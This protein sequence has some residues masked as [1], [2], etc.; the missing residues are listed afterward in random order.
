MPPSK[1][2]DSARH[3][4]HS[5]SAF[6]LGAIFRTMD[7]SLFSVAD[8]TPAGGDET[9]FQ[10]VHHEDKAIADAAKPSCGR[11]LSPRRASP[12][13]P[14]LRAE[15]SSLL[16]PT[17]FW[18]VF[19]VVRTRII[20]VYGR[21]HPQY[22]GKEHHYDCEEHG[23]QLTVRQHR[24]NPP[25]HGNRQTSLVGSPKAYDCAYF[26]HKDSSDRY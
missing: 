25:D 23:S 24:G 19:A 2:H 17:I 12:A 16:R 15:P 3:E 5:T 9:G 21:N 6:V 14:R 1:Y 10:Q 22:E 18:V 26:T 13:V 4:R 11:W 8:L 20:P 7:C